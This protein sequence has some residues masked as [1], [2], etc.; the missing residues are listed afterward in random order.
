MFI[1]SRNGGK[2]ILNMGNTGIKLDGLS[3]AKLVSPDR[4]EVT[5]ARLKQ[6]RKGLNV[7]S[8]AGEA[9]AA[10]KAKEAK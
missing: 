6:I 7:F 1:E 5:I 8:S 2:Y 4:Y 9:F 3:G 10:M